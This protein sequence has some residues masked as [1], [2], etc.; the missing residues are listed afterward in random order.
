LGSWLWL[1]LV[2]EGKI[3]VGLCWWSVLSEINAY[4][5]GVFRSE[6]DK[7]TRNVG[8]IVKIVTIP[9]KTR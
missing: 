9:L 1:S 5:T 8:Y 6:I 4:K 3:I 7:K 2:D